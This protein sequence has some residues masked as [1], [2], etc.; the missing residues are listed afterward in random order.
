MNPAA[1]GQSLQQSF[2]HGQAKRKEMDGQNALSAY[3]M[4]PD[5][6]AAFQGLAQHHPQAAMQVRQQRD[7]QQQDQAQAKREL[8]GRSIQ[9]ADTPEKWDMVAT[10]LAQRGIPE[11][12]GFVGKFSPE[13][14]SIMMAEA[15]LSSHEERATSLQK[16]YEWLQQVN[17][18][19]AEQYIKSETEGNPL[20]AS[21]GD[22]TFTIIPRGT[23]QQ[24]APQQGGA[25]QPGTV[26]DG[27]RFKGGNPADPN[28]WEQ[29]EGGPMPQASGGFR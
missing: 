14:R 25:P 5:D 1:I 18:Q 15:G 19:A 24:Q 16:N 10:Q 22:G 11:A 13:L 21:N 9:M 12:Q 23:V 20:I 28:A 8:I 2:E 29:V 27:Y 6:P 4:N 7:K 17:P 3:A 26:E